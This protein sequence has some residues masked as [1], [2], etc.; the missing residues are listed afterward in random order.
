MLT[1]HKSLKTPTAY[2]SD[3]RLTFACRKVPL[4]NLVDMWMSLCL[5]LLVTGSALYVDTVTGGAVRV[6]HRFSCLSGCD[7]LGSGTF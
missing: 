7:K 4:L 3:Q 6:V 5:M 1:L 2:L